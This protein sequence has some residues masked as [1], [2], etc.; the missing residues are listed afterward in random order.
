[1]TAPVFTRLGTGRLYASSAAAESGVAG[2]WAGYYASA[3]A[4]FGAQAS[5]AQTW[6]D[7]G[8]VYLFCATTPADFA[9]FETALARLLPKLSPRGYLRFLWIADPNVAAAAWQVSPLDA[10]AS[11]SG[12]TLIWTTAR[13]AMFVLGGYSVYVQPGIVLTLRNAEASGYGADIGS[14]G[15]HFSAPGYA[16]V[17]SAAW[18]PMAGN[19]IGSLR[20]SLA[21]PAGAGDGLAGLGVMLRYATPLPGSPTGEIVALS[22]PVLAQGGQAL[23][24]ALRYDPL[25]PLLPAR[26]RLSFF[27]GDLVNDARLPG[28]FVTTLGYSTELLPRPGEGVLSAAG[29]AFCR[30][31]LFVTETSGEAYYDYYLTPDGR[32]ELA[33]LTP[34][35]VRSHLLAQTA[36]TA[37]DRLMLGLNA[38]EYVALPEG[39]NAQM[40]F[41]AG[42]AAFVPARVAGQAP[43]VAQ[44]LSDLGSTA[45]LTVLP[46]AAAAPGLNYYAQPRQAPLFAGG[47]LGGEFLDFHEMTAAQLPT[48]SNSDNAPPQLLPAGAYAGL[49]RD[50]IEWARLLESAAIAPARRYAIGLPASGL[51]TRTLDASGRLAVTPQGLV[52][53]LSSDG[54]RW[55]GV[56]LANMPQ[57]VHTEVALTAVGPP[58]QAAL[59]TNQLFFVVSDVNVFMRASSVAY[60][61]TA[62]SMP[63]LRAAGV[64][65]A[66]VQQLNTYL[67]GLNP[68]Y[69]VFDTEDAFVAAITP[70]AG[71]DVGKILPVAGLLK[72]DMDGWTFQL[73][74]RSWRSAADS[75]TLMLFK[76]CNRS[77]DQ[78]AH[79]S[80]AW[81]WPEAAGSNGPGGLAPTQAA[82]LALIDAARDAPDN[83]PYKRFYL[84][85]VVREDWNGVLFLNAP[86][87]IAELPADLQFIAA[88]VD[89][90]RFYAH[91]LGF[92]LTPFTAQQGAVVL[93]QTAAF[94]LIDYQDPLDLYAEATVPFAFKTLAL[95]ARFANAALVDF[96]ARVELLTNRLFGGVLTKRA[97]THGNNL[98]L[99][100]SYQRV[101]GAPSY[102]FLLVGENRYASERSALEFIDVAAVA[103]QTRQSA[104]AQGDLRVDFILSGELRF[105]DFAPFDLFSYGIAP[106]SGATPAFDGYLRFGNLVVG[107]QFNLAAPDQQHFTSGEGQLSFDSAN[108]HA[109]PQS[110]AAHFPM[111]L[112]GFVA[113]GEGTALAS[114]PEDLGY[115]SVA[116]PL[117]QSRLAPPWYGLV[118]T[119]DLGTLGALAG[120]VGLAVK[121]LAAWSPGRYEGELPVYVG[122]QLPSAKTLGLDWPL[123]GVLRLGFRSF[124]FSTYTADDGGTGYLLRLRRFALSVLGL[125]FPPG[126]AD[127]TLF[128]NPA[129]TGASKLGWYAAYAKPPGGNDQTGAKLAARGENQRQSRSLRSGRRRPPPGGGL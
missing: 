22:M 72:T 92:A 51:L 109:R 123:Q 46:P 49:A 50:S 113:V 30:T 35:T 89:R 48:Y 36:G 104:T 63:Y 99:N 86:V 55:A 66:T 10:A 18:L 122:L 111:T 69:P 81:S 115:A 75:P 59:Q 44:A 124:Q 88:G 78:L 129:A 58:L 39:A 20:G 117:E 128:G 26:S 42:H 57:S 2:Y 47:S 33:T 74:P 38:T 54:N 43:D 3:T 21:L 8:G 13:Q 60:Q 80:S 14:G 45:Y 116:A 121:V 4:A 64:P 110:L 112:S 108:S 127:V 96:S 94:G 67:A 32:Y 53:V 125:S 120:S 61:L 102:A 100:G 56:V 73:S 126:N 83:S 16:A 12:T 103:L 119:L 29:L 17:A 5:L 118:F 82:L 19:A 15:L 97:A 65:E 105:R 9:A 11:G 70:I 62:A 25:Q 77:L 93:A 114:S 40:L 106:E 28:Y 24:L 71:A 87:A 1:M 107:M 101:N 95:T 7:A 98:V 91:H 23:Q 31:P 34:G 79:D 84:D 41:G 6:A 76:Y 27:D 85:V 37:A 90:E 68:P 52:S